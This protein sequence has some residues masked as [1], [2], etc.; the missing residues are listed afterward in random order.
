MLVFD[1]INKGERPLR[2]VAVGVGVGLL[3]LVA[4]LW[5]VQV[6]SGQ[7]YRQ[8]QET[9]SFRTVRVPAIRGRILDRNRVPLADNQPRYRLDVY[10]DELVPQFGEAERQ[11]RRQLLAARGAVVQPESSLWQRFA[12]KF[13]RQKR[14]PGVTPGERDLLKRQARYQVVSNIVVQINSRLGIQVVK[15]EEELFQHW[16]QKRALPFPVLDHLTPAQIAILTEQAWSIPG[17]ELD[18]VPVRFYP[19]GKLAAH[20][21]GHVKRADEFDEEDRAFDY[22]LRDFTGA[23]GIEHAFDRQLRG[24]SGAKSILINSSG[25]RHRQAEI[26]LAEPQPGDNVVT[27]L[28]FGLQKATESSLS[29][30]AG[31][32]RGAVVVLDPRNGDILAIASAPAFDPNVWIDGVTREQYEPFLDP[33]MR[34]MF[35]RA[36]YGYYQPGSTFKIITALACLDAG[37]LTPDN[38]H[39][40]LRTQGYYQLGKRR[41]GD[42]APAG[43]YD[44]RRAFIKSSNAYFIHQGLQLGLQKL[45][46][47]GHRF[48]FGEKPGLRL[49]EESQGLFPE[50]AEIAGVWNQG[51][52]AN[53]SIGQEIALTPV[54]LAVALGAVANGGTVYWPRVVDHVEPADILSDAAPDRIRAGQVRD[55]LALK[56][57]YFDIVRSA[58]RDDVAS[59]EGTGKTARVKDFAVCGKTGTAEVKQG[60]RQTDKI[61]WFASFAP[62]ESPRYV[63][64]VMVE[65]GASGGGTCGP[66]ARRIYEYL[67]DRERGTAALG[68]Q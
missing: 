18:Q 52:L 41:I 7:K 56:P 59:D 28:D 38:V 60:H 30:V 66:V 25:Y 44:F 67:H 9:Q 20:I 43:E 6:L 22:R 13:S 4:G 8:R 48:H 14:K 21:V 2:V 34:P 45:L 64:I 17:V 24:T 58:M 49:A 40:K 5:E 16:R 31:D 19:N 37:V 62:F 54:Q 3:V 36:T 42:H 26:V 35:N 63:V 11:L 10:L 32:E 1:Q 55:Q 15:T 61:T 47:M 33:K 29:Q 57:E 68:M 65:S 46:A 12:A 27:T 39:D 53:V 50:Y 23:I 51:N